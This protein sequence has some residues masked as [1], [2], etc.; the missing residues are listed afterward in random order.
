MDTGSQQSQSLTLK[1]VVSTELAADKLDAR[2]MLTQTLMGAP[3]LAAPA[4]GY[5]ISERYCGL[6]SILS[7][8][9]PGLLTL[10]LSLS[11]TRSSGV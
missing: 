1:S 11:L 4:Q 5:W 7:A 9:R 6:I 2:A 10:S 8:P 3:L